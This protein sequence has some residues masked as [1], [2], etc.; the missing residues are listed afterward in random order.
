MQ[1][2][3]TSETQSERKPPQ[4]TQLSSKPP[5][6][7][8]KPSDLSYQKAYV[9]QWLNNINAVCYQD[10]YNNRWLIVFG[11]YHRADDPTIHD[12]ASMLF[13][14]SH[15][16]CLKPKATAEAIKWFMA[17]Q[18]W[19]VPS[20]HHRVAGGQHGVVYR[21]SKYYVLN[22][23]RHG[24]GCYP[25][26]NV[27]DNFGLL[28]LGYSV[29][30]NLRFFRSNPALNFQ[31]G[32]QC[33]SLIQNFK[34]LDAHQCCM[35][36][37][38]MVDC[39]FSSSSSK[40]LLNIHGDAAT[41]KT[42][43]MN[44]LVGV[45]D[46]RSTP[47]PTEKMSPSQF[48]EQ[49]LNHSLVCLDGATS[50]DAA[51]Q[52]SW[53]ETLQGRIY[54]TASNQRIGRLSYT[55]YLQRPMIVT[56][57]E[58]ITADST[59]FERTL[60]I[61]LKA[62]FQVPSMLRFSQG[63][64]LIADLAVVRMQRLSE[65]DSK[66][67]EFGHLNPVVNTAMAICDLFDLCPD[68]LKKSLKKECNQAAGADMGVGVY[69]DESSSEVLYLSEIKAQHGHGQRL[70][71]GLDGFDELF[72]NGIKPDGVV[73][74]AGYPGAGKSTLALQLAGKLAQH[75]KVL[76]N[77]GEETAQDILERAERLN[78]TTDNLMVLRVSDIDIILDK[79][80]DHE[81]KVLIV[82]SSRTVA[83]AGTKSADKAMVKAVRAI[84]E[85][86][87]R[88]Q[89]LVIILSQVN[90]QGQQ[91][92]RQEIGHIVDVCLEIQA[93]GCTKELKKMGK[94]KEDSM[95][96]FKQVSSLSA[97][98]NRYGRTGIEVFFENGSDG[99]RFLSNSSIG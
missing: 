14:D 73:L 5:A 35:L 76:Y 13:N 19:S 6:L 97:S 95:I 69:G 40:V 71:T 21:L 8:F 12:Q 72:E 74:L 47:I 87:K 26:N 84:T 75:H 2:P 22:I 80:K 44:D 38:W 68:A 89:V 24:A 25:L 58:C 16:C 10:I 34:G 90:K 67:G 28:P 30:H 29:E 57:R 60:P 33:K 23:T 94:L 15:P 61:R 78:I 99:I 54:E 83:V 92:G 56:S 49:S 59:L 3:S 93:C 91:A 86:A 18:V 65:E 45:L 43:L 31:L 41:G 7:K 20:V 46:P 1:T 50:L 77:T 17:Q 64:A 27:P 32:E 88:N 48:T 9:A 52:K 82:D 39:L 85:Y 62:E 81:V 36:I 37:A 63:L 53:L 51:S 70:K 55:H 96:G 11:E 42:R 66:A 79:A 98:K 4:V